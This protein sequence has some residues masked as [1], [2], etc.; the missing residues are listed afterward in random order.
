MCG[1][2]PHARFSPKPLL[3][4]DAKWRPEVEAWAKAG[5]LWWGR[6]QHARRLACAK[7]WRLWAPATG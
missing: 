6:R 7:A 1:L 5:E 3:E 2:K 4:F